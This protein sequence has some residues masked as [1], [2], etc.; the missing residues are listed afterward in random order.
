MDTTRFAIYARVSTNRHKCRACR[1]MFPAIGSSAAT[2]CPSCHST[3]IEQG[4]NPESQLLPLRQYVASRS[5]VAA[6]EYIDRGFSG[7]KESRPALDTLMADAR[8]KKFDVLVVVRF[9][10]FARSVPHLLRALEEFRKLNIGFVSL[11]EAID[12][13]TPMG[14]MVFT[15]IAAVAELERELIRERILAGMDRAGKQGKV[16]GRR[17]AICDREKVMALKQEGLSLRKIADKTGISHTLV[18]KIIRE[19]TAQ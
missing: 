7:S 8:R 19:R 17:Q 3:D 18:A 13:T 10:R 5:S 1:K 15:I 9:D 12:T 4:Q 2:E 6:I 14:R 11:N 16:F